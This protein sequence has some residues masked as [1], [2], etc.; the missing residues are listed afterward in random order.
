[1]VFLL[2]DIDGTLLRTGGA[3]GAAL[4]TAFVEQFGVAD[5]AEV[6]FAG[7]TDRGIVSSLFKHHVIEDHDANWIRLRD[8]YLEHLPSQLESRAGEILP[9]VLPLLERL[10]ALEHV[11]LGLLTG[12]MRRGASIKLAHYDLD[13]YFAWGGFG[14]LHVHRDG[15][16]RE[17]LEAGRTACG[18]PGVE[19]VWVVGDTP[20]DIQCAR[21]IKART[22]A[23]ATGT[24]PREDLA[25]H[26]PEA[27][28]DDLR[29]T[30]QVLA[31]LLGSNSQT[32]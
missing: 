7:R 18:E 27:L 15:V 6:P 30:E 11:R 26:D 4:L 10:A 14:D 22:L 2:F 12:N 9:G 5:P 20:L 16:A 23:V 29:D 24:H 1:M 31:M 17:A 32:G 25:A 28:F 13:R 21:S 19:Q 8:A 3:G